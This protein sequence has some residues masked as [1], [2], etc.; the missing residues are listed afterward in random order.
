MCAME[1]IRPRDATQADVSRICAIHN[2][3]IEDR[4]A[5]LDVDA[6]TLDAQMVWF[7]RHRPH[8]PVVVAEAAGDINGLG[9][10]FFLG[11]VGFYG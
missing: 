3:G 1:G 8:H 9:V 7:H 2:Q 10:C 11:A 5:T 6:H 4:V